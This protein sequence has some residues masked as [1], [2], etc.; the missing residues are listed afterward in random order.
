MQFL[1]E[2]ER[3]SR[4]RATVGVVEKNENENKDEGQTEDDNKDNEVAEDKKD[5][6][7]SKTNEETVESDKKPKEEPQVAE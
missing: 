3:R 7:E 1:K 5:E 2:L 4:I 6:N